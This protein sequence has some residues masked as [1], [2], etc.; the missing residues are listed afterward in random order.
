[1]EQR[2]VTIHVAQK[3]RRTRKLTL[4]T[5]FLGAAAYTKAD[6]VELDRR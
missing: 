4:V 1:M 3:G 5:P 2:E 6:L